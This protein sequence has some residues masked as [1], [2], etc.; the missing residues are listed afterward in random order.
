MLALRSLF[1][2]H[3]SRVDAPEPLVRRPDPHDWLSLPQ[4][5]RELNLSVSTV[6]RM[7]RKGRLRSRIV[8]R[9]GG[10]AYLVHLPESRH[11]SAPGASATH[12]R[13]AVHPAPALH[14]VSAVEATETAD[15]G[16]DPRD[17]RMRML[18]QQVEHLSQAL[19]RALKL[20][21]KT[22]PAGMGDPRDNALDPY[23][24]YRWLVRRHR[25]WPF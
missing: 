22:L 6:R 15:A 20:K 21:Q 12:A 7:I 24:R 17:A 1:A 14:L 5:A 10:Y 18:E 11:G 9:R 4:A 19:C 23:A 25:W 2:S 3:P 8:P 13:L 16:I